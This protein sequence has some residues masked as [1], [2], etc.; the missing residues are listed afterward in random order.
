MLKIGFIALLCI[1]SKTVA[2][3]NKEVSRTIDA[4]S[5]VLRIVTDI[6]ASDIA[7]KYDLVF[8]NTQARNLAYL[9]VTL[10]S[11]TLSVSPPI[12]NGNFTTFSV[13][14]PEASATFKVVSVFTS[15][16]EPYPREI[17]QLDN[18]FV[19]L[20]DSHYFYSPYNTET[21]KVTVKL[22]SSTV[23]S[24]TKLSPS[25][26]RGSTL[27]FGPYKDIKAFSTSPLVVHY[28][29]NFP[30]AK[31]STLTREVEV[32]HWGN[33]AIEELYELKHA[34]AKLKGGFS[35][36]DYQMKRTAQSPSFR[37]LI[38][39][40]PGRANNI[41]Y[42]DQIG[43]ISTSD[44]KIDADGDIE[45][46]VQSRFPMFG[47]WQTQFHLGYSIPTENS[48]SVGEDGRYNL[49]FD[50]FT[51]FNEVWVEDMEIK[52]ILPEGCSDIKVSVPY[53]VEQS[54]TT[55]FTYLDSDLN[56]GRPVIILKAKNIVP[57]HDKNVVIS[58]KF[59]T[60]RMI[61]EPMMLVAVYLL[62]FIICSTVARTSSK[63]GDS[64]SSSSKEKKD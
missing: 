9:A 18:Q 24:F 36:F 2:V 58:Y 63:S 5:S 59:S 20:R 4:T 3:E 26:A 17:G 42:R 48:L 44:M 29:N 50:F 14:I 56:G 1:L 19:L 25:S 64:K 51:V 57:E 16:L 33:I 21:Q 39:T 55:R 43:N 41:Y 47:G 60:S 32:S 54:R 15:T 8:E 6:K 45:L 49:K 38:A 22:A 37:S 12:M 34:G 31:F 62:L 10:K 7:G 35:R 11:K 46:E 27:L 23:E 30:F 53:E 13:S 61:V 40:L 28:V 52:V